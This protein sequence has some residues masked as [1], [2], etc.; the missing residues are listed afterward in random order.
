MD[1]GRGAVV[2]EGRTVKGKDGGKKGKDDEKGG[3]E[4]RREKKMKERK[5]SE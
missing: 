1:E 5:V 4:G 2:K 3:R